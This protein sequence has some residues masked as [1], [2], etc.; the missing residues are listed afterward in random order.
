MLWFLGNF[1][2]MSTPLICILQINYLQPINA[3][4]SVKITECLSLMVLFKSA[5]SFKAYFMRIV[6]FITLVARLV[7]DIYNIKYDAVFTI[8]CAILF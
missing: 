1:I 6:T 8:L 3:T 5:F 4:S 7:I 2:I